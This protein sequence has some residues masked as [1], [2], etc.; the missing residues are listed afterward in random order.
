MPS[1]AGFFVLGTRSGLQFSKLLR[2]LSGCVQHSQDFNDIVFHTVRNDAGKI[3]NDK[4]AS[5]REPCQSTDSWMFGEAVYRVS[6]VRRDLT[7]STG[8]VGRNI[9]SY[10]DKIQNSLVQP[11]HPHLGG[12]F[13]WLEPQLSSH[14]AMSS[15]YINFA[16][17]SS[18]SW[19]ASFIF[20]M[21]HS[22]AS[23]NS[24]IALTARN[25][26]TPPQKEITPRRVW[27]L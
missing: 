21:C 7:G 6:N 25:K 14:S 13:S 18:A 4:F 2:P 8:I 10:P 17:G 16:P 15:C 22:L 19:T 1:G 27:N 20:C 11:S 23:K 26:V 9:F 24:L 3:Y 5:S 12:S